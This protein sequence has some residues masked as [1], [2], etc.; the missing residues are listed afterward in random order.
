MKILFISGLFF[1]NLITFA[2]DTDTVKTPAA[3]ELAEVKGTVEGINETLLDM[4]STV[5]AIKKIKISGYIQAQYQSA[6]SD[7]A[8]SF[9]G[10]D[11]PAASHNRF[12]IRRGR[13]KVN[14]DNDLTQYV[15]Q[16]DATEKGVALKDAYISVKEPWVKAFGLTAGAF[17]R[18]F[19]FE[20]SYSSSSRESPERSRLFQTLFPGERDLGAKIDFMPQDG[21]L[22][23]LN[24]QGGIFTGNGVSSETDNAKDFIGRLGFQFP[25]YDE[26]FEIDG[27]VS[28]YLGQVKLDDA[29]KTF[30][31]DSP[32]DYMVD[33]TTTYQD[34]TY[35]GA[36][37]QLYYDIPFLGGLSLRGEYIQGENPGS[38]GS[39]APYRAGA[40]DIHM[41]N[42]YGYY[43]MY[44]QNLGL[45]NQLVFK[46]DVLDPNKD[47]TGD[48]IGASANTKLTAADV[49]Y[50]TYGVGIVHHWDSN[51]KF[52]LYYDIVE[53]EKVPAIESLKEDLKDNVVTLR[54]QYKF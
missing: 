47:V 45:S 27:G 33:S 29:K 28:G 12:M 34:R 39:N 15:L 5:D 38:S 53:N 40:G 24:F 41:R 37:L 20:I 11:F 6:E 2:Q 43:I 10:G 8:K 44:V 22:S 50:T 13:L 19:G 35:I 52:T 14:Y 4:K 7:G 1:F 42:F 54:M 31:V 16:L 3:E 23:F 30:T 25:F 49:A 26:N 36:D 51:V 9:A 48:D 18:P 21:L 32:T 17:N 46:Y